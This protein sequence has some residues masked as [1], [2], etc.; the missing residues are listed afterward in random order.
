M[1]EAHDDPTPHARY[2]RHEE[3]CEYNDCSVPGCM[4]SE[5]AHL[6]MQIYHSFDPKPC[7]CGFEAALAKEQ[8]R[9]RQI[10]EAGFKARFE[11]WLVE[12]TDVEAA[13]AAYLASPKG[14]LDVR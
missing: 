1:A 6:T 7:S 8:E 5:R 9:E 4:L 12:E 14:A 3:G 11:A 13:F 10:F 2:G